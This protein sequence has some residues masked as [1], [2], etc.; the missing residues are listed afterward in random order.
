MANNSELEPTSVID[1]Q[2][3]DIGRVVAK[4]ATGI[5]KTLT[6]P[7]RE[8][9]KV[10][11]VD[12]K[13]RSEL[14][15]NPFTGTV[16]PRGFL[17]PKNLPYPKQ[18][19]SP[20]AED[21]RKLSTKATYN[22]SNVLTS[23]GE[24]G[25]RQAS[26]FS[27]IERLDEDI[28]KNQK[29]WDKLT[30]KQKEIAKNQLFNEE[31]NP[32]KPE[33][34]LG[35]MLDMTA[36]FLV[37]GGVYKALPKAVEESI[38]Q[39]GVKGIVAGELGFQVTGDYD[40]NTANAIQ[41]IFM[42]KGSAPYNIINFFAA[43]EVDSESLKRAKLAM[44]DL[45][46]ATSIVGAFGVVGATK[47]ML[48]GIIKTI[49]K[50]KYKNS[51]DLEIK[52]TDTPEIQNEK[53]A[54]IGTLTEDILLKTRSNHQQIEELNPSLL[55]TMLG[56]N[57]PTFRKIQSQR[58]K[59]TAQI[60][61]QA[62]K[63]GAGFFSR[64]G[65]S[66][67]RI[68][69][70]FVTSRGF[71]G[72]EVYET[73]Q[74]MQRRIRAAKNNFEKIGKR[75]Q[76]AMDKT[77]IEGIH[78]KV[79]DAVEFEV[80]LG[81]TQF[82]HKNILIKEFGLPDDIVEEIVSARSGIDRLSKIA[83]DSNLLPEATRRAFINNY[84]EYVRRSYAAFEKDNFVPS[85][86]ALENA[87]RFFTNQH[88]ANSQ[89]IKVD[90][91]DRDIDWETDYGIDPEIIQEATTF[92]IR[93]TQQYLDDV[94]VSQSTNMFIRK[95]SS[96]NKQ[97]LKQ[98]KDIPE[99]L[100]TLLGEIQNPSLNIIKS[101]D[102]LINIIEGNRYFNDILEL[103]G[104][105]PK[106]KELYDVAINKAR[107][108]LEDVDLQALSNITEIS[109]N[110]IIPVKTF[111]NVLSNKTNKFTV[112]KVIRNNYRPQGATD[113]GYLVEIKNVDGSVSEQFIPQ[114]EVKTLGDESQSVFKLELIAKDNI[115][116]KL[117]NDIYIKE[118]GEFTEARY[119]FDQGEGDPAIFN[120]RIDMPGTPLH[121]KYTTKQFH[122][123]L[124]GLEET[125][126]LSSSIRTSK[127]WNQWRYL[128][129]LSQSFKTV[130]DWTTEVRNILGGALF[131]ANNGMIPFKNNKGNIRLLYAQMRDRTPKEQA[132]RY[133]R[134]QQLGVVQTDA[135]GQ[136][137]VSLMQDVDGQAPEFFGGAI[138]KFVKKVKDPI[139]KGKPSEFDSVKTKW[140]QYPQKMYMAVDDLFKM[141]AFEYE[142]NYLKNIPANKDVPIEQ[143]EEQAALIVR[144]T[145]PN[146][147]R[148][149]PGF[150][151]LR[152]LPFGNF[153]AFTP[154]IIRTQA[155]IL[156]RTIKELKDPA[157][158]TR[159][160]QRLAGGL[161][162]H[163]SWSSAAMFA[164]H[165]L[166][167]SDD[168]RAAVN[169][170]TEAP[171]SDRHN[172][173]PLI[174]NNKIYSINPSFLNPYDVFHGVFQDIQTAYAKGEIQ[175]IDEDTIAAQAIAKAF[176]NALSFATDASMVADVGKDL[177]VAAGDPN[178]RT[179]KGTEIFKD[180]SV[181]GVMEGAVTHIFRT[182]APGFLFDFKK[183]IDAA[184]QT[185]HK[186]T[187]K[188][189][190]MNVVLIEML[191]GFNLKELDP[192]YAVTY[193]AK[194]FKADSS[195][196]LPT[197]P[198]EYGTN[199]KEYANAFMRR[200]VKKYNVY[201]E[202]HRMVH[203]AL[204]IGLTEFKINEI[205]EQNTSV[206]SEILNAIYE[207]RFVPEKIS[208]K[209][210]EKYIKVFG[211][212]AES[213]QI[214]SDLDRF[215]KE[216]STIPLHTK[217]KLIRPRQRRFKEVEGTGFFNQFPARNIDDLRERYKVNLR[218]FAEGG[219]VEGVSN[220]K[221]DPKERRDPYSG[222]AYAD[223]AEIKEKIEGFLILD[224]PRLKVATGAAVPLFHATLK[225]FK[226]L[227]NI[228]SD[229]GT[230][231]G[232]S[233]QAANRL[234]N[235]I[236][237]ERMKD[238]LAERD[239]DLDVAYDR[240]KKLKNSKAD[241]EIIKSVE[242]EIQLLERDMPLDNFLEN[243]RMLKVSVNKG[244]S[245]VTE[246]AGEWRELDT[247]I[248]AL[249]H[250]DLVKNPDGTK[251]VRLMSRLSRQRK[252]AE[253]AKDKYDDPRD[254]YTSTEAK[255]IRNKIVKLIKEKGYDS[256]EYKNL[257]ESPISAE[258][259]ELKS[260]IIF[261]PENIT[262]EEDELIKS[263]EQLFRD[264][265][266]LGGKPLKFAEHIIKSFKKPDPMGFRNISEDIIE[267]PNFP[268]KGQADQM[269]SA[270]T[271]GK[272]GRLPEEQVKTLGGIPKAPEEEL[273]MLGI[274]SFL[275]EAK[276]KKQQ[277]TKE[278]LKEVITE[279]KKYT[280][281][282][283][284]EFLSGRKLSEH[285]DT[286]KSDLENKFRLNYAL[287]DDFE[288][289]YITHRSMP[290]VMGVLKKQKT[291]EG[292]FS[293]T[294]NTLIKNQKGKFVPDDT[295]SQF[296]IPKSYYSADTY[297][298]GKDTEDLRNRSS[299]KTVRQDFVNNLL[300][301]AKR[302]KSTVYRGYQP[303]RET[304]GL[305]KPNKYKI[306]S[307]FGS[308]YD[309]V[310]YPDT[311]VEDIDFDNFPSIPVPYKE[312]VV[313]LKHPVRR[314]TYSKF[315]KPVPLEDAKF[316]SEIRD[317]ATFAGEHFSKEKDP[318]IFEAKGK[319]PVYHLR[320]SERQMIV[321][322]E[323]ADPLKHQAKLNNFDSAMGGEDEYN[324]QFGDF[325]KEYYG[326]PH[327]TGKAEKI[328]FVDEF[329]SDIAEY[330][331]GGKTKETDLKLRE[332]QEASDYMAKTATGKVARQA[333]ITPEEFR[334]AYQR[335][336]TK[337]H[338]EARVSIREKI[339]D[340]DAVLDNIE[341]A[342]REKDRAFDPKKHLFKA[343]ARGANKRVV[344]I[345]KQEL[346]SLNRIYKAWGITEKNFKEKVLKDTGVPRPE[347]EE[348]GRLRKHIADLESISPQFL[349][350]EL[351][352]KEK[353]KQISGV[354][355]KI[356]DD[357]EIVAQT[358]IVQ[359]LV[360]E[361]TQKRKLTQIA[362]IR[363]RLQR[364]YNNMPSSDA[365]ELD[366]YA[367]PRGDIIPVTQ[368]VKDNTWVQHG[369]KNLITKMIK[370]DKDRVVFS[371]G[372]GQ[373][374]YYK[375]GFE[376]E[377][378]SHYN[379]QELIDD[380]DI[381]KGLRD[382]YNKTIVNE[383]KKVLKKIDP[384]A[385][386]VIEIDGTLT[387]PN[388]M[389]ESS[390][391]HHHLTI[392]NT[393]KL[394]AFVEGAEGTPEGFTTFGKRKGGIV[395]Q[396][397]SDGGKILTSLKNLGSA[398]LDVTTSIPFSSETKQRMGMERGQSIRN[399]ANSIIKEAIERGAKFDI[400][401]GQTVD[402][403]VYNAYMN[404]IDS[405]RHFIGGKM[406]A[407]SKNPELYLKTANT[408]E[409]INLLDHPHA[410]KQD[411]YY[412]NLGFSDK[413]PFNSKEDLIQTI[414]K[415]APNFKSAEAFKI[416]NNFN[417]GGKVLR[418]LA[419]TRR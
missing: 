168:R 171:W 18:E 28:W 192:E 385:V 51:D 164:T 252:N 79:A 263:T 320:I 11:N 48:D 367:N 62:T 314:D 202:F 223:T 26:M 181:S 356:L 183:I 265:K 371:S 89:N 15:F 141:N 99:S 230:H 104:S 213:M 196:N 218:A 215:S 90:D 100:R 134:Y 204:D 388:T 377:F 38:K 143:L 209:T 409:N 103:G 27:G 414:I 225:G 355:S 65:S 335:W 39:K 360:P 286:L 243:A 274:D 281:L 30:P 148:I 398:I 96:A 217:N 250:S 198:I 227:K 122:Q 268:E 251:D 394:R 228:S 5:G 407:Q 366:D 129:G 101:A 233:E 328:I 121:G 190:E 41:D 338:N 362:T 73:T 69:Q 68:K 404:P 144:D 270:L 278:Q 287:S 291:S 417:T 1:T 389:I 275:K 176:H 244:K 290:D 156:T 200:N 410:N 32:R 373:L 178:G 326:S 157:L 413:T 97:L 264:R 167:W 300:E 82:E 87:N 327:P 260:Y 201:Q 301:I 298:F 12:E 23:L 297:Q 219:K 318:I 119:I 235:K 304:L 323:N 67:Y 401:D 216:I 334:L 365:F 77:S 346:D 364:L 395:R 257:V 163:G 391:V 222:Q 293:Y 276:E 405:A 105:T 173:I 29:S 375:T 85:D 136:E 8:L 93:Q 220:V 138:S 340:F 231:I 376:D 133:S 37:S 194:R 84:G 285:M 262:I 36:F 165:Q 24:M 95:Y 132:A 247:S 315:D 308:R 348:L 162:V 83:I 378:G 91:L 386:E 279:N 406:L 245:L 180:K 379:Y 80:P 381:S 345:V 13:M 211:K 114:S 241:P 118:G 113:R 221:A 258:G 159:G 189:P 86:G 343:K 207:N 370:Q 172:K 146:Y 64:I 341:D 17:N 384:D 254:F 289:T 354:L 31:G 303:Q 175:N 63:E 339:E 109:K 299:G 296:G 214:L 7:L 234:E 186:T 329:Q 137:W 232:S 61:N 145:F 150:K 292:G 142:L 56:L 416:T 372:E 174:I 111:V 239:L 402:H 269:R 74:E 246:D 45:M 295:M 187:G 127:G 71:A 302:R 169:T 322:P 94:D 344:E 415:Q 408:L 92:G 3:A 271:G 349:S 272:G 312:F 46:T 411:V 116:S 16:T 153:V 266:S 226:K 400:K 321:D 184:T 52:E 333:G 170:L 390:V 236:I 383:A 199:P 256:I 158:R 33:T 130:W 60:I 179:A 309:P 212:T 44:T 75:L 208:E 6:L 154:E 284:D 149:P 55:G 380:P 47:S 107:N 336:D 359:R 261:D 128:K 249:L 188:A 72:K 393:P 81:I 185:P 229:L 330:G 313:S 248:D 242:N 419:N 305:L 2:S 351:T 255:K 306:Q 57:I 358:K 182:L 9:G 361:E 210:R 166:G 238:V 102:K 106:N 412:N 160:L 155:N 288:T 76:Y 294:L 112:G 177:L 34:T 161:A 125:A 70:R 382:F 280:E 40:E 331:R 206:D 135:L 59:D 283:E 347:V 126:F 22:L 399:Y 353:S 396:S 10:E 58:D 147:D 54:D 332:R 42:E 240:L 392:K 237:N 193:A 224:N 319:L 88:I 403:A 117:A 352:P 140:F 350:K 110:E 50:G 397:K 53:N 273:E 368:L 277:V 418:A 311:D 21:L 4:T 324:V 120:T 369:I 282:E 19:P 20:L 25:Q 317:T 108:E 191:T 205:V 131:S 259:D 123:S 66:F 337:K 342:A 363:Q 195:Y 43:Q 49:F 316:A 35:M 307:L 203:A 124:Q 197:T 310:T 357:E 98:R 267:D 14:V 253:I 78:E 152:D 374:F 139:W 387:N 325:A 115:L 151:A